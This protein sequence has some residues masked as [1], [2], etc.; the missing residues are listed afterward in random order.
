M[1]TLSDR[2]VHYTYTN[3]VS[4]DVWFKG[5]KVRYQMFEPDGSEGSRNE[6]VPFESAEVRPGLFHVAWNEG[7]AGDCITLL[8][9][10]RER[11]VFA[12]GVAGYR[13]AAPIFLFEA[14]KISD[15]REIY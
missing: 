2:F 8:L 6:D 4:F 5:G 13:D 7:E 14:G 9:D 15:M 12:S 10:L 11:T 1:S 3:G